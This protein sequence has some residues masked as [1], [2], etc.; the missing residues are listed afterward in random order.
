MVVPRVHSCCS[1]FLPGILLVLL[2]SVPR[3]STD[4]PLIPLALPV[5]LFPLFPLAPLP[6]HPQTLPCPSMMSCADY[7]CH[8]S[9]ADHPADDSTATTPPHALLPPRTLS[10]MSRW[11]APWCRSGSQRGPVLWIDSRRNKRCFCV[12]PRAARTRPGLRHRGCRDTVGRTAGRR[13]MSLRQDPGH[14]MNR[15]VSRG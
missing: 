5:P 10:T 11:A 1:N 8:R 12:G 9:G 14:E 13:H 7:Y 2:H 4:D 3:M 6:T 15:T